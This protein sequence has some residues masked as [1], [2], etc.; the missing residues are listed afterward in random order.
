M[1]ISAR[2]RESGDPAHGK[3]LDARL[4]GHERKQRAVRLCAP[5]VMVDGRADGTIYLNSGC[6]LAPYP[7]KLTD[8][9]V[10]W[11][12]ATPDRV[13]MAERDAGGGWRTITYAQTLERV[14]RIGAALL[15]RDLSPERPVA[16]LSGNSIEHA[17]MGLASMYVGIPSAPISPAYSLI[18]QDFGKLRSIVDLLTP[19]LVF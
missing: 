17:L 14:R 8:R 7:D 19:G 15:Q 18:S 10:H 4:R 6:A 2:P 11:A 1:A 12:N 9:L 16:I 5:E 3:S 13:F